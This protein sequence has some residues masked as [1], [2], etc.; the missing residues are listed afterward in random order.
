MSSSL[1]PS[2]TRSSSRRD[3]LP[4]LRRRRRARVAEVEVSERDVAVR[5]QEDVLRLEV[6]VDDAH[7]VEV[8][9]GDDDLGR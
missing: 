8:L 3:H 9:Q 4:Q 1:G 5:V 2:S 7:E 6:P